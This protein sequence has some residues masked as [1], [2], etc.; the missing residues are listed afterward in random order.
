VTIPPTL[1]LGW[2]WKI[3]TVEDVK[4]PLSFSVVNWM[5][6]IQ[7]H[8]SLGGN[9]RKAVWVI[10]YLTLCHQVLRAVS[11]C[12][13]GT[14]FFLSTFGLVY[15]KLRN[16]LRTEK[17]RKLVFIYKLLNQRSWTYYLF[18]LTSLDLYINIIC[19]I[20]QFKRS[21]K[22]IKKPFISFLC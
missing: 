11:Y 6:F 8:P 17:A 9:H 15:S 16:R 21:I 20:F 1:W 14:H 19:L 3:N 10:P 5:N 12:W 18:F 22:K 7:C 4:K 2:S 13:C